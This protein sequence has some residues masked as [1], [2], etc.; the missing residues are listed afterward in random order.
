MTIEQIL[1]LLTPVLLLHSLRQCCSVC[2]HEDT[3][4]GEEGTS[5]IPLVECSSGKFR[6]PCIQRRNRASKGQTI[7]LTFAKQY[8]LYK[9]KSFSICELSIIDIRYSNDENGADNVIALV[10]DNIIG[11][12]T[13]HHK[14]GNGDFWNVFESSGSV[15]AQQISMGDH[16]LTI[17]LNSTDEKG[18]EIDLVRVSFVCDGQCPI[19][20]TAHHDSLIDDDAG[21]RDVDTGSSLSDE[22]TIAIVYSVII[23]AILTVAVG[24][25]LAVWYKFDKIMQWLN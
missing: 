11:N 15:G 14:Q 9:I 22:A 7:Y 6:T 2:T 18:V 5:S 20:T 24:I 12:F 19:V 8:I 16:I 13:T 4:Q 23:L 21:N 25:C 10:D 17:R 1:S 3:L